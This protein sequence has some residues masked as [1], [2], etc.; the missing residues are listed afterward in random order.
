M[1]PPT[2]LKV[3][4]AVRIVGKLEKALAIVSPN[5]MAYLHTLPYDI[6][7]TIWKARAALEA[8]ITAVES[9]YKPQPSDEDEENET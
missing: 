6:V 3:P 8:A 4:P 5:Q 9:T 2:H 1:K 7:G